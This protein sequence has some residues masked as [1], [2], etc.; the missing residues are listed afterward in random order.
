MHTSALAFESATLV[1]VLF[2]AFGMITMYAWW[3][4]L[5]FRWL[6]AGAAGLFG[7]MFYFG[8]LAV[9]AGPAPIIPRPELALVLRLASMA[10]TLLLAVPFVVAVKLLLRASVLWFGWSER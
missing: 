1:S 4:G 10:A 9:S 6:L 2:M 7:L 8:L 3:L 5:R